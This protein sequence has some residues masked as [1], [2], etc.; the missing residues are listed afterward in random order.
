MPMD[1]ASMLGGIASAN[2][3]GDI[4]TRMKANFSDQQSA[5]VESALAQ[6]VVA[7]NQAVIDNQKLT[8]ELKAQDN[9]RNIAASLGTNMEAQ[10]QV[11]TE[12]S[13]IMRQAAIDANHQAAVVSDLESNNNLFTNPAGFAK[14]LIYGD[15]ERAKLA[16]AQT[17]LQTATTS[18]NALNQSTTISAQTQNAIAETRSAVTVQAQANIDAQ[19]LNLIA[20]EAKSKIAGVDN[21]MLETVDTMNVRHTSL[22]LSIQ[23]AKRAEE[24]QAWGRAE[25]L[26]RKTIRDQDREANQQLVDLFNSGAGKFGGAPVANLAGLKTQITLNKDRADFYIS[27]GVAANDPSLAGTVNYGSTPVKAAV[28]IQ[29]FNIKLPE[30]QNQVATSIKRAASTLSAQGLVES[31]LAKNVIEANQMMADKKQLPT[32]QASWTERVLGGQSQLINPGDASNIYALPNIDSLANATEMDRNPFLAKF[33]KPMA[34]AGGAEFDPSKF[35]TL[36]SQAVVKGEVSISDAS[37]GITWMAQQ[38]AVRNN[39]MKNYGGFGLPVQTSVNMPFN[40]QREGIFNRDKHGVV[41]LVDEVAVTRTLLQSLVSTPK[42]Q[43]E[44]F[45]QVFA[46]PV[47][48]APVQRGMEAVSGW[49]DRTREPSTPAPGVT[50]VPRGTPGSNNLIK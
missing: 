42:V 49:L 37:N 22:A 39:A 47:T 2:G 8:G 23:A 9:A 50:I 44:R 41:N 33:I 20:A 16:G 7:E 40:I 11:V 26:D 48:P 6:G 21:T 17:R 45:E 18:L 46:A 15:T 34:I 31:G 25:A 3:G 19:K 30:A 4:A 13:T 43:R 14:D 10:G 1:L 32:L 28:N 24:Q 36:A 35:M 27:Q 29:N 38:L 5:I 12:L